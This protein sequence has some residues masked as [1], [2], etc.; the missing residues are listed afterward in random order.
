MA[1][2]KSVLLVDD[3]ENILE[4]LEYWLDKHNY[5]VHVASSVSNAERI[6]KSCKLNFAIVD[7]KL[8]YKS[9]YGGID[10]VHLVKQYH[11]FSKIII[12]S[13]HSMGDDIKKMIERKYDAFI[14]KGSPDN[15]ITSVLNELK[16]FQDG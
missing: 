13:A 4:D 9:E 12:L 3:Q 8:D 2:N 14:S 1:D 15:Y 16:N 6:I 7:L 5:H 10:V 11:P